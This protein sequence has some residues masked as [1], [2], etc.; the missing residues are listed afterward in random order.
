[1]THASDD[2]LVEAVIERTWISD[3]ETTLSETAQGR[4]VLDRGGFSAGTRGP[5]PPGPTPPGP[6]GTQAQAASPERMQAM[7]TRSRSDRLAYVEV[8]GEMAA[9]TQDHS[10]SAANPLPHLNVSLGCSVNE[11]NSALCSLLGFQ[12]EEVVGSTVLQVVHA[13]DM[14]A[15]ILELDALVRG[16]DDRRG[17]R[18]RFVRKGG[19]VV[20]MKTTMSVIRDG[21]EPVAICLA[22]CDGSSRRTDTSGDIHT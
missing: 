14:E 7:A 15:L 1:M 4:R 12:R 22:L 19:G 16:H 21:D 2:L 3:V 11:A 8:G 5:S 17:R 9:G 6:E 20:W 13:E 18:F 10:S